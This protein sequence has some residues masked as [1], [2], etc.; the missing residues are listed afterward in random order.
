M[1][2]L[3]AGIAFLLLAPPLLFAATPIDADPRANGTFVAP[4]PNVPF[5]A[6]DKVEQ[7]RIDTDSTIVKLKTTR[8]IARD[9]QGRVYKVARL[10]RPIAETGTPPICMIE[11]YDPQTKIYTLIYPRSRTFWKGDLDRTPNLLA[12]EY[13]YGLPMHH[14]LPVY[15]FSKE[16][17]L[18]TQSML[19]MR[20]HGIRETQ[21]LVDSTGKNTFGTDEYWYSDDLRMSLFAEH[22]FPNGGSLAVTV[23]QITRAEPDP[24]LLEIPAKYRQLE[25]PEE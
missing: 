22:K 13:F 5:T 3:T 6:V 20:V 9:S 25:S 2:R 19:G 21:K 15:K 14:G 7:T 23:T 17:E 4:I 10:L 18:G 24:A 12:Q 16:E 8:A 1:R 11:F